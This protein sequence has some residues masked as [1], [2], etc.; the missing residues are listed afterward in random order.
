VLFAL[1]A[2]WLTDRPHGAVD[3]AYT[4]LLDVRDAS[5]VV[6]RRPNNRLLL[7]DQD[8]VAALCGFDDRD[9]LLASLA[10]SG[11]VVSYALD[12]TA[13]NARQALQRPLTSRRPVL[14][15]G[16]RGAPRL[17]AV[18]E[19]LVEHDGEIVLAIDAQPALDR[20]CRCARPRPR[21]AP[22]CRCHRSW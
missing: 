10:E 7:A 4:H 6:S 15:R 16:R 17:R 21:S 20:C 8:E 22:G 13:R 12:V 5:Q 18:G 9:D 1:A 3:V 11:R 19:G 14:V 2:T